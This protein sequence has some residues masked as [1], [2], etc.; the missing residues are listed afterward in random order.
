MEAGFGNG[1][2]DYGRSLFTKA[3]AYIEANPDKSNKEL[4]PTLIPML[5]EAKDVLVKAKEAAPESAAGAI[6][7]Q[8]DYQLEQ[9]GA[10]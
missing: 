6:V 8:L 1:I 10:N 3:Q 7:D 4:A 2:F 9:L 5:K